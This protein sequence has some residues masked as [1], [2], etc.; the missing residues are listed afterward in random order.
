MAACFRAE[1]RGAT[2]GGESVAGDEERHRIGEAEVISPEASHDV[3]H[4]RLQDIARDSP[5]LRAMLMRWDE[6]ALP[7]CWLV[8]GALAQSVWN[9]SFGFRASHGISDINL[10]YFDGEDLTED[11]EALDAHRIARL[12]PDLQL[13]LD[14]KNEARVHLW[15]AE[16]FGENIVPY[17]STLHAITTFPATAT[18][19]GI[20]PV[21]ADLEVAA[22]YGLSDLMRCVVRP[23]KTQIT[24]DIYEGKTRRWRCLWPG[25]QILD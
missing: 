5:I 11:T 25:L 23:N 1:W 18:A 19:V 12:F 24:R 8:A 14:V 20:R 3:L 13:R 17:A 9:A 22:P 21:G 4:W 7:D 16:K 2:R 6:I 15:Y 10:V